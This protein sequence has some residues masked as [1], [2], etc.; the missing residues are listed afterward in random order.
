M[1]S[2]GSNGDVAASQSLS[3]P[4]CQQSLQ[5]QRSGLWLLF[6]ASPMRRGR[7]RT[8]TGMAGG[9]YPNALATLHCGHPRWR[10]IQFRVLGPTTQM[11][12]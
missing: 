1:M 12:L 7:W 5:R 2:S 9:S 4:M 6:I 3:V 10:Q 11:S 8:Q